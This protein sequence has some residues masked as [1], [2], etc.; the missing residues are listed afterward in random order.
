[1]IELRVKEYCHNCPDFEADV[2]KDRE[3]FR[4]YDPC[5]CDIV[6]NIVCK[7]TVTC[8]YRYRCEAM[9]E[10]LETEKKPEEENKND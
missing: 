7:T 2:D 9:K 4:S 5:T 3:T 10:Y 6:T 1:M 8:K